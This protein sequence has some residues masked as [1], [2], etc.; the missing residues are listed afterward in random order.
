M[1]RWYNSL[2]EAKIMSPS[3][4]LYNLRQIVTARLVY[5]QASA[6]SRETGGPSSRM[7]S[8]VCR[9]RSKHTVVYNVLF[10]QSRL[11]PP[12]PKGDV[13]LGVRAITI[14]GQSK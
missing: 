6:T 4:S 13:S 10:I 9:G 5:L 12:V 8:T 3:C 14:V 7:A 2:P 1:L 11:D